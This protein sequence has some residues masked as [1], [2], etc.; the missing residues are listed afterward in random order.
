VVGAGAWVESW[1][2]VER[3][4]WAQKEGRTYERPYLR[5]R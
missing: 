4:I 1:D 5:H 2:W 3:E